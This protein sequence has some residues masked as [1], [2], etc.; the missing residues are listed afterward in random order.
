MPLTA[1]DLRA[2]VAAHPLRTVA[3]A[4][5]VGAGLALAERSRGPL[6]RALV[7]AVSGAVL[8]IAREQLAARARSWIDERH[9]PAVV[10]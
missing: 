2:A 9:A 4:F 6:G 3:L 5:A 10:H 8:S 1:T 7:A